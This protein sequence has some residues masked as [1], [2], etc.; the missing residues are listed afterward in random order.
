[1]TN[2]NKYQQRLT[3]FKELVQ[4]YTL[5]KL[6]LKISY[7]ARIIINSIL[8]QSIF[9]KIVI[10]NESVMNNPK[11]YQEG[12]KFLISSIDEFNDNM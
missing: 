12:I 1:M 11:A 10:K 3:N 9:E 5:S 2:F 8:N 6:R 4:N 7:G